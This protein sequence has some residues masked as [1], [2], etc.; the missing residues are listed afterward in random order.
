MLA[1]ALIWWR[2]PITSQIALGIYYALIYALY[3]TVATFAYMP[4]YAL[5]PELTSDYDERTELTTTRMFF[6]I[7]GSLVAFTVPL[8]IVNGFN[9]AHAAG[10]CSWAECLALSP[11]S[12]DPGLPRHP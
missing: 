5:T 9:P 7:F 12:F 1:F 8:L 10:Y 2:P 6:S 11:R 4:Y 3:D